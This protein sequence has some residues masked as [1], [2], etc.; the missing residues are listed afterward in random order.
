MSAN[1]PMVMLVPRQDSPE[2]PAENAL[3]SQPTDNPT[4]ALR[5]PD[6]RVQSVARAMKILFAVAQ[7][8][9]G[10]KTVNIARNANLP[11]Q[12]TYHLVH[13]LM[14]TGMLRQNERGLY[15]LGLRV[16]TL[17]EA[18]R[19][20]LV[21]SQH[22]APIVREISKMTGET[23]YATG[24]MDGEIVMLVTARGTNPVHATEATHGTHE[25]AHARAS[26]KLLL[27]FAQEDVR[28]DYLS[29]HALTA[30]TNRTVTKLPDLYS[31]FE[32]IRAQGYAI[33]NEEFSLGLC[34]L[35]VPLDNGVSPFALTLSSPANRFQRHFDE[36]LA[37]MRRIAANLTQFREDPEI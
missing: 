24:W 28:S 16:G 5:E 8:E 20:Q 27:A 15:V 23:A 18:F 14:A 7:S 6:V 19:R 11:R 29:R 32:R 35:A 26:G 2:S 30:R 1:N 37:A 36:Y 34:C 10:L 17:A 21:P 22:L 12:A 31:E 9:S 33:D 3:G 13:T 25:D 4:N